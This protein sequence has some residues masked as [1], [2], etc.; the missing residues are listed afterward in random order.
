MN[1][2]IMDNVHLGDESIVGALTFIKAGE[3]IPERS[4]VAGNPAKIIKQ[5]S[6]EMN[7]WKTKGTKL[8]QSLP[9]DM[10]EHWKECKALTALPSN[11]PSKEI[12]FKTWNEISTK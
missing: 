12:L 2:V 3:K 11:R 5:V 9:K 1:A 8:Y 10:H 7:K 6:D 4:V